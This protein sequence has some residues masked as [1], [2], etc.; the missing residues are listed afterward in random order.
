MNA[1]A[2]LMTAT[3]TQNV[4]TP[5]VRL[6]VVAKEDFQEMVDSA[7]VRFLVFSFHF[8]HLFFSYFS[9]FNHY[10]SKHCSNNIIV[11]V[12]LRT[13]QCTGVKSLDFISIFVLVFYYTFPFYYFRFKTL[14]QHY[15]RVN[16]TQ[17]QLIL[18]TW[19]S[20]RFTLYLAY[21]GEKI[22]KNEIKQNRTTFYLIGIFNYT[23][24]MLTKNSQ[25]T[26]CTKQALQV[27][28]LF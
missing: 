24:S 17:P 19:I 18:N 9:F 5:M 28:F 23:L 2:A 3:Q 10:R 11:I 21:R 27:P 20:P 16:F 7:Q 6:L 26:K 8:H 15:H 14:Q 25:I 4:P 22:S 12:S 13:R 1:P